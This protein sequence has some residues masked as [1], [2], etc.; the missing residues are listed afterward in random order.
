MDNSY[1]KETNVGEYQAVCGGSAGASRSSAEFSTPP[2]QRG[3]LADPRLSFGPSLSYGQTPFE[4]HRFSR[5]PQTRP[6]APVG[7]FQPPTRNSAGVEFQRTSWNVN[8]NVPP[9]PVYASG[10]PHLP[11]NVNVPPPLPVTI[12]MPPPSPANTSMPL[13]PP[14]NRNIPP[15]GFNPRFP[16]P[17]VFT[18]RCPPT[19]TV[20]TNDTALP[21]SS[22]M[23][24]AGPQTSSFTSRTRVAGEQR[25]GYPN[26]AVSDFVSYQRM[27]SNNVHEPGSVVRYGS[28]QQSFRGEFSS[29]GRISNSSSV[30]SYI[31]RLSKSSAD[32]CANTDSKPISFSSADESTHSSAVGTSATVTLESS[33]PESRRRRRAATRSNITV[34]CNNVFL[35]EF[36]LDCNL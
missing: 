23:V 5:L 28:V 4:S 17:P 6:N 19:V 25:F 7:Q 35:S 24:T 21:R 30:S 34:S 36:V 16:P 13:L 8:M 10:P 3:Q 2:P 1:F 12:N 32:K 18:P 27:P 33:V 20:S 26:Q 15:P 11:V 31:A 22:L 14:V 9:P 29:D